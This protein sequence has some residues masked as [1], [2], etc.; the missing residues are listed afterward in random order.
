M[1]PSHDHWKTFDRRRLP[2][3]PTMQGA[4]PMAE[5]LRQQPELAREMSTSRLAAETFRPQIVKSGEQVRQEKARQKPK[6]DALLDAQAELMET[7]KMSEEEAFN[8]L[9]DQMKEQA[10]TQLRKDLENRVTPKMLLDYHTGS[11]TAIVTGKQV[12]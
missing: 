5:D 11:H 8:E 10:K 9:V 4:S 3:L 2:L 1:F 6:R 12:R 7:T